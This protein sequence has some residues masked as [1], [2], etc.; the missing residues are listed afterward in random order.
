MAG[1]NLQ[2]LI[3]KS[4]HSVRIVTYMTFMLIT[5]SSEYIPCPLT[6]HIKMRRR[7]PGE[8]LNVSVN[9]GRFSFRGRHFSPII[10]TEGYEV[11]RE[12]VKRCES[13]LLF[14]CPSGCFG[15]RCAHAL[16]NRLKLGTL[17][18]RCARVHALRVPRFRACCP[19]EIYC[20][21]H[22]YYA[23]M[24]NI[25]SNATLRITSKDACATFGQHALQVVL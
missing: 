4:G 8:R 25:T 2:Q 20:F 12:K 5:S 16:K 7:V 9:K 17:K 6:V 24:L 18:A 11:R 21:S 22:N 13:I 3:A 15:I 14:F 23:N 19:E 10:H 1:T